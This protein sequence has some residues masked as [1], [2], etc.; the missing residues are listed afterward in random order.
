M[1]GDSIATKNSFYAFPTASYQPETSLAGGVSG[2]FYF[3]SK[4]L[5]RIS[6]INSNATYTLNNQFIISSTP[7]IFLTNSN[8]YIYSNISLKNY[9]D[10][11]YGI[12]NTIGNTSLPYTNSNFSANFQ[13]QYI[14]SDHFF[15]GASLT[16]RYEDASF[17]SMSPNKQ[18]IVNENLTFTNPGWNPYQQL[19]TGIV[20]AIDTRNNQFYPDNGTFIK[21]TIS[22]SNSKLGSSYSLIESTLDIRKY[23][24]LNNSHIIALQLFSAGVLGNE[25]IPFQLLPTLGG[26]DQLRGFRQGMYRDKLLVLSQAEYRLLLYKKWRAALFCSTG[27][28]MNATN[29]QIE[30]VKIGYGVGLRYRIN[31]ARVNLRV[32]IAKNN[33]NND[34]QLYITAAEAF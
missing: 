16:M 27:D 13:P 18:A 4:K 23:I 20:M 21:G 30:K 15:I 32:D 6:S 9:P 10:E 31:N 28:V 7:K 12:G 26:L 11:Y 3:S 34:L 24:P 14:F 5:N 19:S 29:N 2:A 33:Y 1:A 17:T 8:W 25:G 22:T